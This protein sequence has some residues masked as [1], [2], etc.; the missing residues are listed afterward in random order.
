MTSFENNTSLLAPS[1]RWVL[2]TLIVIFACG[3]GVRLLD[4]TDP[5]LDYAS[6]R[7]LRAAL[8][9]RGMYY[10]HNQTAPEW[11]RNMARAQGDRHMIEPPI[12]EALVATTYRVVGGEH[13]WIA[14]VYTSLFWVLGGL[15]LFFFA[16]KMVSLDGAIIALTY[17]LFNPFGVIVSRSFLPEAL[18]TAL[19]ILAWWTFYRWHH[20]KTWKWAI[21]AGL[22]AGIAIF[23]KFTSVFFLFF[24]MALVVLLSKKIR[25][26]IRD[27]QMWVV[28]LLSALPSLLYTVYG[29]LIV[30]TLGEQFQGRFF[31]QLWSDL[32]FY[33]QWKNGLGSVAGHNF[34]LLTGLLGLLFLKDRVKV[35][36]LV[37]VWA[38]YI[39]YG[40]GFSYHFMT[41]RYY[42]LPVIPL[43]AVS[44]GALADYVFQWARKFKMKYLVRVGL[45]GLI[46]IGMGG[47]YYKLQE[48]DYRHEPGW[49]QTVASFIGPEAKVVALSQNYSYRI[50]YYGWIKPRA[51]L[52][53]AD[54]ERAALQ[55]AKPESFS[56]RFANY[57]GGYDY[58]LVTQMNEL[59]R[60][61]E[62]HDELYNNYTIYKEGGGY[63]IFDLKQPL[64]P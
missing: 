3:L 10:K 33:A 14:R 28:V 34:I 61:K 54:T 51:W 20:E 27:S 2:I 50:S 49:Y 40:F 5:P 26:S 32:K 24:G 62:L 8:M 41:H 47:N 22:S 55:G 52:G 39:L 59:K 21:I 23:V 63:V 6:T 25:E 16:R 43:L 18:M 44:I 31:P 9:A 48:K 30:G 11:K 38:G 35:G 42:H 15:A 60:Q 37:G 58:F 13:V 1:K 4:L 56:E 53:T 17:Y 64:E 36:F 12:I 57:I 45:I 46:L 19:I 29:V 7:Q